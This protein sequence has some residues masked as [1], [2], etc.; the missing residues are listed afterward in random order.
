MAVLLTVLRVRQ[1]QGSPLGCHVAVGAVAAAAEP[2]VLWLLLLLQLLTSVWDQE[3]AQPDALASG[4][5]CQ[6][7]VAPQG[8]IWRYAVALR[9]RGPRAAG[10]AVADAVA[11]L[12]LA[13]PEA[14]ACWAAVVAGEVAGPQCLRLLSQLLLSAQHPPAAAAAVSAGSID[15][16]RECCQ[17]GQLQWQLRPSEM[18]KSLQ[19]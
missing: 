18:K 9:A 16:C 6:L 15:P 7:A 8:P 14:A 12:P 2:K 13:P 1:R 5:A 10:E 4:A 19:Q 3:G 17:M 11:A